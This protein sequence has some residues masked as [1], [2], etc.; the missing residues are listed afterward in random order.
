MM[1]VVWEVLV[2][3]VVVVCLVGVV[4]GGFGFSMFV[5]Q[6][7]Q[8]DF[9]LD[10][11]GYLCCCIFDFVNVVFG[12]DVCVFSICGWFLVCYCVVSECGEEWLCF[13]YFCNVFDFKK[14]YLFVFFIDFNNLYNLMCWQFENYLQFLYNV[15]FMLLFG[16]KFEVIYV[17]FQ[18]CLLWFEFM[19][20]YKFMDYGCMWVFFQFYFMQCCKMY[21][22]LYCV[23]IIKQNEQ[24]VVCIDLYIDMCLFLGGFIVFSMLDGWFLVYDFDNLLVLQ[25]WVMVIDICVV[26]SCLYMFGDEN[27]DDLE[28]VCDLYF[29]VVFDL[30][31][32][33]CCKCNGY[34]VCCVCDCD[35]SLV[36]DCRYNIVGLECDCCKLFY[37][38]WFWQCVIVCEVNEC[39]GEWG[40]VWVW[41]VGGECGRLFWGFLVVGFWLGVLV[42]VVFEDGLLCGCCGIG[43]RCVLVCFGFGRVE[44]GFIYLCGIGCGYLG[45]YL[46]C[47]VRLGRSVGNVVGRGF[48]RKFVDWFF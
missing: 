22:W 37:Y 27:E 20:I 30:Q 35:D 43:G 13:C 6:V 28:L 15:M 38:D 44:S 48:Y 21:N 25:D 11:N 16:K 33:G 3:L 1:C 4:C 19:V 36:C 26:F 31:V 2:V 17:S 39:V 14:V 24:E 46:V 23:F 5:G 32:G 42:V 47:L 18:F 9:C 10:E 40:V 45:F 34:V 7:V 8:F 41:V 12:K 29:Y